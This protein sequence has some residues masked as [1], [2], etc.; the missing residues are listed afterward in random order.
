MGLGVGTRNWSP[1]LFLSAGASLEVQ[2]T[3]YHPFSAS[4]SQQNAPLLTDSA[5]PH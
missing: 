2:G 5:A 4:S 3:L 1:L